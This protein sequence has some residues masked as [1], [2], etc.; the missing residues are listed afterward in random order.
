MAVDVNGNGAIDFG[1]F[2]SVLHSA[3]QPPLKS[4]SSSSSPPS[5][6][7]MF[8][9]MGGTGAL[10]ASVAES[11]A[12]HEYTDA[13]SEFE[14]QL[15][16]STA[17]ATRPGD[18]GNT[19]PFGSPRTPAGEPSSISPLLS[20]SPWASPSPPL[21]QDNTL[22][23]TPASAGG[24]QALQDQNNRS[25]SSVSFTPTPTPKQKP[26]ARKVSFSIGGYSDGNPASD[27]KNHTNNMIAARPSALATP[28]PPGSGSASAWSPHTPADT[29]AIS[30]STAS[31]THSNGSS[32]PLSP[33]SA[34]RVQSRVG[35][36][37]STNNSGSGSGSGSGSSSGSSSSWRRR[38]SALAPAAAVGSGGGRASS[39][40]EKF[41][42]SSP[43]TYERS[44]SSSSSSAAAPVQGGGAKL[45]GSLSSLR[46][47]KPSTMTS[48]D[49]FT[50]AGVA[51]PSYAAKR[52]PPIATSPVLAPAAAASLGMVISAEAPFAGLPPVSEEQVEAMIVPLHLKR[53]VTPEQ[54]SVEQITVM[55]SCF[56]ATSPFF[57][58]LAS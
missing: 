34:L 38:G 37:V 49:P 30:P 17:N 43:G 3:H 16:K 21:S 8:S 51:P 19:P 1:E 22:E 32:P 33:R 36:Q 58:F 20:P 26:L 42:S 11:E 9:P 45:Q 47:R 41:L 24:T 53:R 55:F 28:S 27:G 35:A 14:R 18:R 29:D 15:Q 40:L 2:L 10:L 12:Y 46:N 57:A 13:V 7:V 6:S 5:Q 4:A 54:V 48:L 25:T 31:S 52:P 23:F 39:S 44:P 50:R 56:H